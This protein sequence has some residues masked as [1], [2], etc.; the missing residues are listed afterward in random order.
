MRRNLLSWEQYLTKI[1]F[2]YF[3]VWFE[4]ILEVIL[5]FL[6]NIGQVP[7]LPRASISF[8][9][10]QRCQNKISQKT[11][12]TLKVDDFFPLRKGKYI[13]AHVI[14]FAQNSFSLACSLAVNSYLSSNTHNG[15]LCALGCLRSLFPGRE[16]DYHN[17]L[18]IF[19]LNT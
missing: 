4:R 1:H 15:Y 3:S 9:V 18:L 16:K 19:S 7:L 17:S 14:P 8:Q 6:S 12:S 11:S 13:C 10:K 5:Q 2:I